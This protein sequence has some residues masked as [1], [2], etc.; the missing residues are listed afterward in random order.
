MQKNE[1]E[2]GDLYGEVPASVKGLVLAVES[3]NWQAVEDWC[4]NNS[5]T[6]Q[7]RK[8]VCE[9]AVGHVVE[10]DGH[11]IL[12]ILLRTAMKFEFDP[13]R[14]KWY[15]VR[16]ASLFGSINCVKLFLE[17]AKGRGEVLEDKV[18]SSMVQMAQIPKI[19]K[20][21]DFVNQLQRALSVFN[22]GE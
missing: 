6:S 7:D 5:S 14:D 22:E 9:W 1:N 20:S 15:A 10:F 19:G 3:N 17:Y 18:R 2:E 12:R 8:M 11:E 13:F 4:I 16:M 21:S